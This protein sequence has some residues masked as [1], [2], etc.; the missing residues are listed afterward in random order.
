[1]FKNQY[2]TNPIVFSPDG[3]L[4]QLNFANKASERGNFSLVI[5]S[6]NHIVSIG[7]AKLEKT[8]ALKDNRILANGTN[9]LIIT[10]GISKDGRFL[11]EFIKNKKY[12]N[13]ISSNR[14]CQIPDIA[15][16][17]SNIIARNTFYSQT[18]LFG[19]KSI[20]IGYD[21]TGPLIFDFSHDGNY[22][23]S[24]YSAQGIGSNKIIG[25]IEQFSDKF[26]RLSLDELMVRSL[27]IYKQSLGKSTKNIINE[28]QVFFSI[29]GK[30][31]ELTV[32]RE[33]MIKFYLQNF[34]KKIENAT[35][36][37]NT[38]I[39]MNFKSTIDWNDYDSEPW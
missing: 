21:S 23:R 29:L 17:L 33:K 10:T 31:L 32:F 16:F 3:Q 4:L 24:N 11:N 18:R 25:L 37:I 13:E 27:T 30:N 36:N 28:K 34:Y 5:K 14:F 8:G 39:K 35:N 38:S 15:S 6:K 22:Q 7:T 20:L 26:E 2:N 19:I 9:C 12:E 1:M